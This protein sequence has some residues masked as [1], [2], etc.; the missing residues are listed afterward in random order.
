MIGGMNKRIRTSGT[1]LLFVYLPNSAGCSLGVQG[2]VPMGSL[3]YHNT[4]IA[5]QLQALCQNL[6][7]GKYAGSVNAVSRRPENK[8]G[9]SKIIRAAGLLV[10]A[11]HCKMIVVSRIS[12]KGHS[13]NNHVRACKKLE[14]LAKKGTV[15]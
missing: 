14:S 2:K 3:V 6:F 15:S 10:L 13:P 5:I 9:S 1:Y 8:S 7:S 4:Q 12:S 11:C